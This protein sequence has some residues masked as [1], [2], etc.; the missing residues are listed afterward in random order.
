MRRQSALSSGDKD[1]TSTKTA[2][3]GGMGRQKDNKSL[4]L[5][6]ELFHRRRFRVVMR[7]KE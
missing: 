1:T 3:S 5:G 2:G 6:Q 4:D 7:L